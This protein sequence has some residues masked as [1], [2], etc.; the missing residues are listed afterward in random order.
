NRQPKPSAHI[1][2]PRKIE[3][4]S[5]LT[6]ITKWLTK[7][8]IRIRE[9][10]KEGDTTKK[11]AEWRNQLPS[12]LTSTPKPAAVD[13]LLHSHTIYRQPTNGDGWIETAATAKM[14]RNTFSADNF[15][16]LPHQKKR[17]EAAGFEK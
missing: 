6:T 12:L 16:L 8:G 15:D 7:E 11:H 3:A 5:P 9:G 4:K 2:E 14:Y 1:K 13:V 17:D 10:T